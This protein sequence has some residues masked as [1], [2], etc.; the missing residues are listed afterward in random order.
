MASALAVYSLKDVTEE[1]AQVCFLKAQ[2]C[3]CPVFKFWQCMR[4]RV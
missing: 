4:L 2:A 3:A 1:K